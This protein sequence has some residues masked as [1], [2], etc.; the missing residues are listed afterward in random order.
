MGVTRARRYANHKGGHKYDSPVPEDKRGQ[1]RAHGRAVL[2]YTSDPVK[3]TTSGS[4]KR[5]KG[6]PK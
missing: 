3:A 2:P 4:D 6:D 5:R 1:S